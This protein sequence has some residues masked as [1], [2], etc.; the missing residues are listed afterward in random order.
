MS[1]A[2]VSL[3]RTFRSAQSRRSVPEW[4]LFEMQIMRVELA[5]LRELLPVYYGESAISKLHAGREN[6]HRDSKQLFS[7]IASGSVGAGKK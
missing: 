6:F 2:A 7:F 5:D 3:D 1:A 4:P